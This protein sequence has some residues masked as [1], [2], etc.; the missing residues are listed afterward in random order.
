MIITKKYFMKAAV[1]ALVMGAVPFFAFAATATTAKAKTPAAKNTFY[2]GAWVPYWTGAA[3]QE[4]VMSNLN[5]L[6]EVSPFSYEL[7]GTGT[8]KDDLKIG[9]GAWT[10][11]MSAVQSAKVKVIPTIAWFDTGGIYKL[12]SVAKTRQAEEDSILSLVKTNNFDGID[13]DFEAMST[14]T[15]PY[16]SL[17][18]QGLAQRLHPAGKT[19]TCTVVPRTPPSSLYVVIPKKI[20]YPE[21]YT[22][23]NKY[24][25]EDGIRSRDGRPQT[26]RFQ[27]GHCALCADGGSGVGH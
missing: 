26:E 21:D 16:Y 11:W 3:G 24:C 4:Q 22:V 1:V 20:V 18:I 10:S 7:V 25:D 5:S 13:I 19:L 27:R 9:T 23:L 15:R 14:S 2:Y 17:F 12:L 6:D 8:I